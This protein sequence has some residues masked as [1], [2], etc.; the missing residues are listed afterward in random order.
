MANQAMSSGEI[1]YDGDIPLTFEQWEGLVYH[2]VQN[3]FEWAWHQDRRIRRYGRYVDYEDLVQ[4]ASLALLDSIDRWD[5]TRDIKFKTYA[6]AAIYRRLSTYIDANISPLKMI[7]EWRA[8][9]RKEGIPEDQRIA[10]QRAVFGCHNF[11]QITGGV[12][13]NSPQFHILDAKQDDALDNVL[14]E[15]WLQHCMEQIRDRIGEEGLRLL[16]EYHG[17]R[18]FDDLAAE[19]GITREAIRKRYR[20]L[21]ESARYA[22]ADQEELLE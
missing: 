22:V 20:K 1:K 18:S 9:T 14:H 13:K 11:S 3:C 16:L 19:A 8:A 4:E 12:G 2:V 15:D 7:M 21:L 5:E 10:I 6:Y 17:G